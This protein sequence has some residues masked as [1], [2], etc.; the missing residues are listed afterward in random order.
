MLFCL[1]IDMG[2]GFIIDIYFVD[3][4]QNETKNI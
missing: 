3:I 2:Y 1:K 4:V